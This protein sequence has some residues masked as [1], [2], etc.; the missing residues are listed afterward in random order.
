MMSTIARLA[1]VF[2]SFRGRA[3]RAAFWLVSLTWFV[4]V[5]AFDYWWSVHGLAVAAAHDHAMVNAVL[6]LG[7]LP[8]L[9]SCVAISVKR[10]HDR[11]KRAWWL[12]L[13][14]VVPPLL[15]V[16]GSL[17][18]LDSGPS[19]GLMI[20]S[21]AISLW[22]LVELGFMRGTRGPNRFGPD[23]VLETSEQPGAMAP[24]VDR[25]EW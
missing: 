21:L 22:A 6:V 9:A 20:A 4:L 1:R 8:A 10:L 3:G 23:P 16:A 2:F 5:Q 24:E 17:N 19:V 25:R 11:N 7:S 15:Q 18:T 12:L 13:F 14:G